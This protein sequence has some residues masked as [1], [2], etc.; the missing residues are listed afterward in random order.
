MGKYRRIPLETKEQILRRVKE[1]ISAAQAA[2]DAGVSKKTVYDWLAKST[3]HPNNISEIARLR[4]ENQGLYEV[5]GK[6]TVE[7]SGYKKNKGCW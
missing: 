2:R 6:L 3:N 1:G 5:I 7:L 4:K